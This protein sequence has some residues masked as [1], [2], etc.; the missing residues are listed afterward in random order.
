G[1][2]RSG[3]AVR[4]SQGAWLPLEVRWEAPPA[5]ARGGFGRTAC[6]ASV[7]PAAW[8]GA[9]RGKCGFDELPG[10]RVS[11]LAACAA[12]W[13]VAADGP[14]RAW[15]PRSAHLLRRANGARLQ[16]EVRSAGPTA[17]ARRRFGPTA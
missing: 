7:L 12:C 13:S 4:G 5:A 1:R 15:R 10:V 17:A 14:G 11:R 3:A 8:L 2:P 9:G 16:L 6:P